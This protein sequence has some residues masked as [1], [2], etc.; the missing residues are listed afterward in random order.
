M[1]CQVFAN[2][3]LQFARAHSQNATESKA[4]W[5]M[6]GGTENCPSMGGLGIQLLV[7]CECWIGL[8]SLSHEDLD[9]IGKKIKKRIWGMK[10]QLY[11]KLLYYKSHVNNAFQKETSWEILAYKSSTWNGK[12]VIHSWCT[13]D[14]V[15]CKRKVYI[16]IYLSCIFLRLGQTFIWLPRRRWPLILLFWHWAT[17]RAHI[18]N[19][20]CDWLLCQPHQQHMFLHKEWPQLGYRTYLLLLF[21]TMVESHLMSHCADTP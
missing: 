8:K 6:F 13:T 15:Y 7:L 17:L 4:I 5:N 11:S 1:H 21:Y 12:L 9:Q 2:S 10:T 19:G 20:R 3:C 18:H 16:Y 14:E